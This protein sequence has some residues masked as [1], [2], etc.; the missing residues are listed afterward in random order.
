M[1]DAV[2]K[3]QTPTRPDRDD[4]E[5]INSL[6]DSP[7]GS[8]AGASKSMVEL[9]PQLA[10]ADILNCT[11]PCQPEVPTTDRILPTVDT[12]VARPRQKSR[13]VSALGDDS[14][15]PADSVNSSYASSVSD[16]GDP[17]DSAGP[18]WRRPYQPPMSFFKTYLDPHRHQHRNVMPRGFGN[19]LNE[20]YRNSVMIALLGSGYFR[21]YLDHWLPSIDRRATTKSSERRV[22]FLLK[23]IDNMRKEMFK[24]RK[25]SQ[26]RLD[27]AMCK[28]WTAIH[29]DEDGLGASLHDLSRWRSWSATMGSDY[30]PDQQQSAGEFLIWVLKAI[31]SQLGR[32][33]AFDSSCEQQDLFTAEQGN[34]RAAFR[35]VFTKRQWCTRCEMDRIRIPDS[36]ISDYVWNTYLTEAD[37][38]SRR[39]VSLHHLLVRDLRGESNVRCPVNCGGHDTMHVHEKRLQQ[40]PRTLFIQINRAPSAFGLW[41]PDTPPR[42]NLTQVKIPEY[43]K[44]G[45]WLE[46]HVHK[47]GS[48][49]TYRL[50]TMVIHHGA[51]TDGGHY[52]TLFRTQASHTGWVVVNDSRVE[53]ANLA[54][55]DDSRR[56]LH[57]GDGDADEDLATPVLLV[58]DMISHP[59]KNYQGSTG[60]EA[61]GVWTAEDEAEHKA[62][63]DY[64]EDFVKLQGAQRRIQRFQT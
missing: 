31:D 20:C 30:A 39:G 60:R 29:Q 42:K 14:S 17:P 38:T 40:T 48:K 53:V 9:A 36:S 10:R 21:A 22:V 18:V 62:W 51:Y 37:E 58:Y 13:K 1:D 12:T 41:G 25:P 2:V 46:P 23:F 32:N 47:E 57:I 45:P 34:F 43:L 26:K 8:T 16:S 28:F 63:S 27:S 50:K 24:S 56:S 54:D 4:S 61:Q 59:D 19:D 3:R 52:Y 7:E 15:E 55:Y 35:H 64:W 11:E 33:Y 6:F 44:F 5:S 49:M